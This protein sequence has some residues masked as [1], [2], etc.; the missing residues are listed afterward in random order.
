MDIY[1]RITFKLITGEANQITKLTFWFVLKRVGLK[2][3]WEEIR[4]QYDKAD[5][6]YELAK[7]SVEYDLYVDFTISDKKKWFMD[8]IGLLRIPFHEDHLK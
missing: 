8:G 3:V 6:L 2:Y 4:P 1:K 5:E 7:D